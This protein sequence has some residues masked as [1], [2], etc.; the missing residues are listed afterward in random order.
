LKASQ[1]R[2]TLPR[3][4]VSRDMSISAPQ[5]GHSDMAAS[6]GDPQWKHWIK[7]TLQG[8]STSG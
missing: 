1:P 6:S 7:G 8:L 3:T 2:H 4:P 5:A